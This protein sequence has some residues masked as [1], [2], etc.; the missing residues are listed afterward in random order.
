[1]ATSRDRVITRGALL[2]AAGVLATAGILAAELRMAD[3]WAIEAVLAIDAVAAIVLLGAGL[4][5]ARG[6][7]RPDG[8]ATALIVAGLAPA[9]VAT[10]ALADVLGADGGAESIAWTALVF[11]AIAAGVAWASASPVVTLI[12]AIALAT[13]SV[14][15]VIWK[16]DPSD[17]DTFRWL[18]LVLAVVFAVM[19]WFVERIDKHRSVQLVNAAGVAVLALVGAL[20]GSAFGFPFA[21]YVADGPLIESPLG[22]EIVSLL[23]C[24]GLLAYAIVRREPGP[25]Y[26]GAISSVYFI[27]AAAVT[28]GEPTL[29]G[30]PLALLALAA[31]AL[32]AALWT[33]TEERAEP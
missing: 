15:A 21:F 13:T 23:G 16:S 29:V 12:A 14:A 31:I 22:W 20:T 10:I 7:G 1:M 26:L 9:L 18:F 28:G 3:E 25:G 24:A 8:P 30:W 33:S 5:A 4:A 27:V 17:V 19:A 6:D 11:A 32:F 2:A